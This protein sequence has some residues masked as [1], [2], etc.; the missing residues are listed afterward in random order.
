VALA[1]GLHT[2]HSAIVIHLRKY[3]IS[4]KG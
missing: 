4:G 1:G 3:G 2:S